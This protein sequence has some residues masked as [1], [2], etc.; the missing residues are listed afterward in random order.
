MMFIKVRKNNCPTLL[1]LNEI[2]TVEPFDGGGKVSIKTKDGDWFFW[3]GDLDAFQ[4]ALIDNAAQVT[5]PIASRVMGLDNTIARLSRSVEDMLEK[6]NTPI[7]GPYSP[8]EEAEI[9][10]T[11]EDTRRTLDSITTPAPRQQIGIESDVL[12]IIQLL[13][14]REWAEH[15]TTTELGGELEAEITALV[16]TENATAGRLKNAEA[17]LKVITEDSRKWPGLYD[18]IDSKLIQSIHTFS[19]GTNC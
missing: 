14:D 10:R 1:H 13:K 16:D 9:R 2:Y 5:A 3:D 4:E 11:L 12:A 18:R 8:E 7:I 15:C 17:L 19:D 6:F